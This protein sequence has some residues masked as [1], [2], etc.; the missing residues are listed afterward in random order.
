MSLTVSR[1][2]VD[3][4][5]SSLRD[6]RLSLSS[7][8]RYSPN[9][10]RAD[11]TEQQPGPHAFRTEPSLSGLPAARRSALILPLPHP[12]FCAGWGTYWKEELG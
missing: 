6:Q 2:M 1:G 4:V 12:R 3:P 10:S 5:L 9:R 7:A 8:C 11:R